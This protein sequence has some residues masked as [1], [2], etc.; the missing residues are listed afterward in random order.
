MADKNKGREEPARLEGYVMTPEELRAVQLIELELLCEIDRICRKRDIAYRLIGGTLLGAVRHGGFIPWDDD[1]DVALFRADYERF[2]EAC[3]TELDETRFYFQDQETTPGYRWGY[4]K[5]RRRD[6]LFVRLGQ[7]NMPY[8]QGIFVDLFP[9]DYLPDT[10][11][12]RRV[13]NLISF[14][15]RKAFWSEVGKYQAKGLEKAVYR[16]MSLIPERALKASFFKYID[17][18]REPTG[19]HR[20]LLFPVTNREYG[21]PASEVAET[22]EIEFEGVT[23]KA[24]GD[25]EGI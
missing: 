22:S 18:R 25:I 13:T 2:R 8:E 20:C 1:A 5:L 7:E 24:A 12:G 10:R 15:Y 3:K 16:A 6:T 14:L 9:S 23:F 21:Y 19:W 4:G 11:L 17:R